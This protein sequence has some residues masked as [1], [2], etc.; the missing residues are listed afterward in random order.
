MKKVLINL[1]ILLNHDFINAIDGNVFAGFQLNVRIGYCP[2]RSING[3][4]T[5]GGGKNNFYFLL[6]IIAKHQCFM[7]HSHP[8][9]PCFGCRK[10]I[11]R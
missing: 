8:V 6:E 9:V 1:K 5:G 3:F 2:N 4:F 10:H 7:K 11:A